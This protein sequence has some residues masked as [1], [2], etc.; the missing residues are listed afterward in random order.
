MTPAPSAALRLR[1]STE[2]LSPSQC[3]CIPSRGAWFQSD[4]IVG[5]ADQLGVRQLIERPVELNRLVRVER[6]DAPAAPARHAAVEHR[7][8]A[9]AQ[10]ER[11]NLQAID[12]PEPQQHPLEERRRCPAASRVPQD[13]LGRRAVVE[14]A[15]EHELDEAL[16]VELVR[17]HAEHDA[18]RGVG[19]SRTVPVWQTAQFSPTWSMPSRRRRDTPIGRSWPGSTT[20]PSD[21]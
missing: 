9:V 16:Q 12:Q 2:S 18:R 5:G 6:V 20:K 1:S 13:G 15:V 4:G 14:R 21:A 10:R 11:L 19:E 8:D 7:R 17:R 3:R